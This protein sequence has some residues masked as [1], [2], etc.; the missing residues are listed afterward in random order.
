VHTVIPDTLEQEI[1]K[2]MVQDWPQAKTWD[3]IQKVTTAK[4]AEGVTQVI[5]HLPSKCK[6]LSTTTKEKLKY[7]LHIVQYVT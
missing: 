6:A 3:S 1:E 7:S 4:R 2:I 5:E